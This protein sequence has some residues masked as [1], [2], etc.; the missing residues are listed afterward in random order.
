MYKRQPSQNTDATS[1]EDRERLEVCGG[2]HRG[3]YINVF[4]HGTYSS[5]SCVV[6]KFEGPWGFRQGPSQKEEKEEVG[7]MWA[8][9]RLV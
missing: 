2:F 4:R 7:R 6:E 9:F 5:F 3:E 8:V 1:E